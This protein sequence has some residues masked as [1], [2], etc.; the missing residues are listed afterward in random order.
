MTEQLDDLVARSTIQLRSK[1]NEDDIVGLF[2]YVAENLPGK[3]KYTIRTVKSVVSMQNGATTIF[4]PVLSIF[5]SFKSN[6]GESVKF[7]CHESQEAHPN[8]AVD[9]LKFE[10][11]REYPLAKHDPRQV[12][13][14]DRVRGITQQYLALGTVAPLPDRERHCDD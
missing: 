8:L 5:G 12:A 3:V 4:R 13:L 6:D 10:T 9:G 11:I 2:T 14:W 7:R 1:F